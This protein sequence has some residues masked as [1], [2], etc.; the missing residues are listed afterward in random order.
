M[1]GQCDPTDYYCVNPSPE[2]RGIIQFYSA[3]TGLPGPLI[4]NK[5]V[6]SQP[7]KQS[8]QG[9]AALRNMFHDTRTLQ[10]A[11]P[12]LKE[13]RGAPYLQGEEIQR[14]NIETMQHDQSHMKRATAP[15]TPM[16]MEET[17]M[18]T[19]VEKCGCGEPSPGQEGAGKS[20]SF[21]M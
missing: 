5:P 11:T 3:N 13:M 7:P 20:K 12:D 6:W 8:T 15:H 4:R 21:R 19:P 16:R 9:P 10:Y 1:S 14:Y 17:P 18:W 2:D